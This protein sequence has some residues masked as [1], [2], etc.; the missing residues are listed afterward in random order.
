MKLIKKSIVFNSPD[1]LKK[2]WE[3]TKT[4]EMFR[5]M[6]VKKVSFVIEIEQEIE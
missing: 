3:E 2:H 5:K 4:Q 1:E 6:N